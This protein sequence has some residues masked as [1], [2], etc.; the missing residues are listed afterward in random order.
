ME[1]TTRA[2]S[3]S[4]SAFAWSGVGFFVYGACQWGILAILSRHT[5]VAVF[6]EYSL[7]LAIAVPIS[8]LTGLQLRAVQGTDARRAFG[9]PDYL[10]L[11]SIATAAALAAV[12]ACAWAI[13]ARRGT[14]TLILFA[15]MSKCVESISDLYQGLLLQHD[16]HDLVGKSL[17]IR[18][19]LS[20]LGFAAGIL[21]TGSAAAG[22]GGT[23][24]GCFLCLVTFDIPAARIAAGAS[25]VTGIR[26]DR[27]RELL[28]LTAPL[29]LVSGLAALNAAIPRY[30]LEH[31]QGAA[32]L[33]YFSAAYAIQSG[34]A[35]IATAFAQ[36]RAPGMS[37]AAQSSNT[38]E[39]VRSLVRTLLGS[40]AIGA[41]GVAVAL[42][43]AR[44]AL[45]LAFG[46]TYQGQGR[47]LIAMMLAGLIGFIST[48]L[49]YGLMAVRQFDAQVGIHITTTA[50]TTIVCWWAVPSMGAYG[51][52]IAL[53]GSMAANCC[54]SSWFILRAIRNRRPLAAKRV[55]DIVGSCAALLVFAPV[56]AVAAVV[57]RWRLGRPVLF[58]QQRAGR[59]G[60]LFQLLKFRTMTDA[61]DSSGALLPDAERMTRLS[62]FLRKYSIDELPQ[63]INV[64]RG[65]MSLVGPRPLLPQYLLRYSLEQMRRHEVRPGI[66]GL[67]Q[68][69][70]RNALNWES[71]FK[72][73][74]WYVDHA[75]FWLDVRVLARTVWIVISAQGISAE[76]SATAPEFLGDL[77]RNSCE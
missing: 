72:L 68:I 43:A 50:I 26:F 14:I 53:A 52:V 2:P 71:K 56:M 55:L 62:R 74:V 66:T 41:A 61:R 19:M 40:A 10:G 36:S 16:R 73:D 17:V 15:G 45:R 11:R 21:T 38:L 39:F 46:A 29:G 35:L 18:G 3:G 9:F 25:T 42:L 4:R 30:F 54:L 49:W 51:A 5:S 59:N 60:A 8:L 22:A 57:I 63:F 65:E 20:V 12:A 6:G 28:R 69:S 33:G 58:R 47:L 76:G 32:A 48:A 77:S 1:S 64:V 27:W 34:A 75:D 67:T 70:G 24:F 37:R 44:S 31:W 13:G 7:A 23:L